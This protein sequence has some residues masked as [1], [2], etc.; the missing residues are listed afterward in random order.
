[1]AVAVM[2]ALD[3]QA[4]DSMLATSRVTCSMWLE[5][6]HQIEHLYFYVVS[7]ACDAV[8]FMYVV[9]ALGKILVSSFASFWHC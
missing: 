2:T 1:M 8:W 3:L 4:T 9:R 5:R 6:V 7:Q